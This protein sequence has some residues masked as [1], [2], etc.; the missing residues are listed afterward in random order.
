[1]TTIRLPSKHV[2]YGKDFGTKVRKL[3]NVDQLDK[4]TGSVCVLISLSTLVISECFFAGCFKDSIK[5]IG[6]TQ[7]REKYKFFFECEYYNYL[8]DAGISECNK[9]IE[10]E[11]GGK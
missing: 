4:Q 5:S 10:A 2:L 9:E 11:E 1:M 6:E 7:F 8:I 3:L